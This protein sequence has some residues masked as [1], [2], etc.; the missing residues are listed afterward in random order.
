MLLDPKSSSLFAIVRKYANCI[1]YQKLI[2]SLQ[3]FIISTL[4]KIRNFGFESLIS[5]SEPNDI[6]QEFL[7]AWK[8]ISLANE[9]GHLNTGI[10]WIDQE[11]PLYDTLQNILNFDMPI[12]A[13]GATS[14]LLGFNISVILI[15]FIQIIFEAKQ[16]VLLRTSKWWIEFEDKMLFIIRNVSSRF[17]NLLVFML[18]FSLL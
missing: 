2:V 5:L 9:K 18:K 17:G 8:A 11:C 10:V 1:E 14:N 4:P 13:A 15:D 12:I 7:S 6:V 3:Q 16:N